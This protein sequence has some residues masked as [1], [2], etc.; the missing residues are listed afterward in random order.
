MNKSHPS[1]AVSIAGVVFDLDGLMFNTED[2]YDVV[3]A[4]FLQRHDKVFTRQLKRQLM[5]LPAPQA[6]KQLRCQLELDL[7]LADLQ[8]AIAQGLEA[9]LADHL[10]P[11]PGLIDLLEL[12]ESLE[13]PKAIATSST[14]RFVDQVLQISRMQN[15]FEFVLTA[16]DVT[17]GKPHPEIYLTSALRMGLETEQML[18]LE[19]SW[20]GSTAAAASGAITAVV[21]GHHSVGQDFRHADYEFSSLAEPA[22]VELI[23]NH[24]WRSSDR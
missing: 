22:L 2:L 11:L 21:P 4:E 6:L 16:E 15:R 9:Q 5:G 1:R 3:I 18:V 13:L 20:H 10:Q 14:R 12:L 7:S 17:N 8:Q 23:R 19:D 24:V